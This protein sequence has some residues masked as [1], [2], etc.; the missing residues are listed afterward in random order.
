MK[1]LAAGFRSFGLFPVRIRSIRG[2]ISIRSDLGQRP[3]CRPR[4]SIEQQSRHPF[5]EPFMNTECK[6]RNSPPAHR[7]APAEHGAMRFLEESS[8][9]TAGCVAALVAD[10]LPTLDPHCVWGPIH[11]FGDWSL[12]NCE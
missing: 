8:G 2:P 11:G 4:M 5:H 3:T 10:G 6:D 7:L 9:R 12:P 1:V